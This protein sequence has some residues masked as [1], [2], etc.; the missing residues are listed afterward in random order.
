[1]IIKPAR[2]ALTFLLT[3]VAGVVVVTLLRVTFGVDLASSFLPIIP[4]MVAATLE[5]NKYARSTEA[6]LENRAA[7]KAAFVMTAIAVAF[8]AVLAVLLLSL[9]AQV[10][11]ATVAG[12]FMAAVMAVYTVVWLIMNR[13]FLGLGVRNERKVQARMAVRKKEADRSD[14]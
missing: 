10:Q 1:M 6:P 7:W 3:L 5:G 14:M 11:D 12:G 4:A 2:Y 9:S 8:Y 13:V